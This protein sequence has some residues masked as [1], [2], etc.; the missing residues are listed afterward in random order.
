MKPCKLFLSICLAILLTACGGAGTENDPNTNEAGEP[1]GNSG[2]TTIDSVDDVM[3]LKGGTGNGFV[4]DE[5]EESNIFAFVPA[6]TGTYV[7]SAVSSTGVEVG[8]WLCTDSTCEDSNGPWSNTNSFKPSLTAGETYYIQIELVNTIG[9]SFD[10]IPVTLT[11]TLSASD[12]D[13]SNPDGSNPDGSNPDGSNPDGSNPDGSNPDGSSAGGITDVQNPLALLLET[14]T[15]G[16]FAANVADHYYGFTAT[17]SGSLSFS[18]TSNGADLSL[19]LTE[20]GNEEILNYASTSNGEN[21]SFTNA[22]TSGKSYVVYIADYSGAG[23]NYC[24]IVSTSGATCSEENSEQGG[25]SSEDIKDSNNPTTLA[26]DTATSGSVTTDVNDHYYGFTATQNGTLTFVLTSSAADL[27]L[28]LFEAGSS[29]ALKSSIN[30]GSNESFEY[31]VNSGT[32]YVVHVKDY[33]KSGGDYCLL[34]SSNSATTCADDSTANNGGEGTGTQT[35]QFHI[36]QRI[37][38]TQDR[39][40]TAMDAQGNFVV[41]WRGQSEHADSRENIYARAYNKDGTPKTDEFRVN[42]YLATRDYEDQEYLDVAMNANG[43]FVVVWDGYGAGGQDY[44]L[45]YGR[46]FNADGTAKTGD[47]L[48]D[49]EQEG[50]AFPSV[51]INSDGSFVVSYIHTETFN[52]GVFLRRFGSD[53]SPTSTRLRLT[54]TGWAT[55]DNNDIAVDD[56]GNAVVVW[57][58]GSNSENIEL[59]QVDA[60]NNLGAI[61]SVNTTTANVQKDPSIAM[62]GNGDFVVVWEDTTLGGIQAQRFDSTANKLGSEFYV[63]ALAGGYYHYPNITMINDGSFAIAWNGYQ[64]DGTYGA[65]IS[66]QKYTSDGVAVGAAIMINDDSSGGKIDASIS[67]ADNGNIIVAWVESTLEEA[68]GGDSA[69]NEG[70]YAKLIQASP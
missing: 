11:I 38:D 33:V 59:I 26:L 67:M 42:Q 5:N 46:I 30:S 69:N 43:E 57:E 44:N 51:A 36:N 37:L 41:V 55:V 64:P 31:P 62:N 39:P 58:V 21:P 6:V 68:N 60:N 63:H 1:S 35:A 70:I 24:L 19:S 3:A 16:S 15:S 17:Q 34:V 29:S 13:G 8:S 4:F 25:S 28:Y 32:R 61:I 54:G 48:L 2:A 52:Y 65:D 20:V 18:L 7:G 27:D 9:T 56:A 22:I 66:F 50:T 53:G 40:E 23:G 12:S 49:S 10:P 14:N 45:P 47:I